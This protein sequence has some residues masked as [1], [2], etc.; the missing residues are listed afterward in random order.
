MTSAPTYIPS[1]SQTFVI[2]RRRKGTHRD[3]L[4]YAMLSSVFESLFVFKPEREGNNPAVC[5]GAQMTSVHC[6]AQMFEPCASEMLVTTCATGAKSPPQRAV[7][8][9]LARTF[10]SE[11][12]ARRGITMRG[13]FVIAQNFFAPFFRAECASSAPRKAKKN[14]HDRPDH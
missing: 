6:A 11:Y 10:P 8:R 2:C 14:D 1:A 7:Q 12:A 13:G 3:A 5:P 9:T 4:N